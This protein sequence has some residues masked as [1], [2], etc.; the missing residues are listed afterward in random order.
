MKTTQ[1]NKSQTCKRMAEPDE[2][3]HA[4]RIPFQ[5]AVAVTFPSDAQGPR[6]VVVEDVSFAGVALR[7][8]DASRLAVGQ[9][10]NVVILQRTMAAFI[11]YIVKLQAKEYRIGAEFMPPSLREARAVVKELLAL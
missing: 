8:T 4:T 2:R 11:K 7:V 5:D 1:E 10:V 3:R 6:S 9:R